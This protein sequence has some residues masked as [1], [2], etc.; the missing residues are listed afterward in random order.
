[1]RSFWSRLRAATRREYTAAAPGDWIDR[2]ASSGL[3]S[4]ASRPLWRRVFDR[5]ERLAGEP[6]EDAVQ[7]RTFVDA[8]VF[9]VRVQKALWR[10]AERGTRAALHLVNLP[11]RSDVDRLSR[12]VAAMRKELREVSGR[13][14]DPQRR[15]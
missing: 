3:A 1:M 4:R 6:L 15:R 13:L 5:A 12:Q 9:S 10:S 7:T 2:Y 11:A 8:L 14:D